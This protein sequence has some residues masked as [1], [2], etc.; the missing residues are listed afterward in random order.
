MPLRPRSW[1]IKMS[2]IEAG[3]AAGI[4][5]RIL[6]TSCDAE[7]GK[8]APSHEVVADLGE[9]LALLRSRFL[10]R[11]RRSARSRG[12]ARMRLPGRSRALINT[13][14]GHRQQRQLHLEH[15]RHGAWNRFCVGNAR[16]QFPPRPQRRRAD[17]RPTIASSQM[18]ISPSAQSAP[19][20]A[21]SNETI[22]ASKA[23]E[24]SSAFNGIV[25]FT[26]ATRKNDFAPRARSA[27]SDRNPRKVPRRYTR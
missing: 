26:T 27:F 13:R 4:G 19:A 1:E 20:T 17:R 16:A 8:G 3:A 22:D 9:A 6:V 21:Q 5:L 7:E 15:R 11:G 24:L 12:Q 25:T 23:L 10:A 18:F 14:L 2:D